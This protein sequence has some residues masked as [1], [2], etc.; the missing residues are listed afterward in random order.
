[1][2]AHHGA[3]TGVAPAPPALDAGA[4]AWLRMRQAPVRGAHHAARGRGAVSDVLRALAGSRP[5]SA[6]LTSKLGEVRRLIDRRRDALRRRLVDG[7]PLDEIAHARARLLDGM[8]IGLCH[9]GWL[10]E[11]R[12]AEVV[13]PLAVIARG[14]YGRNQLAP[15][16]SADLLFLVPGDPV[17]LE[18]GLAVSRFVARELPALGW[19]ASVARRTMRGCLA[20]T[21]LDPAIASNLRAARLVWG[22]PD[23]FADLR[24]ALAET[25]RRRP[26]ERAR[27]TP[28]RAAGVALAA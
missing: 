3:T 7:A 26:A 14:D 15:W 20:E 19:Q 23:L 13:P 10:R 6:A 25:A 21:L 22:C 12:P 27:G 18:Q 17:R 4:A 5:D 28:K 16:A 2:T 11:L 9:L 8:L 1:M 24:K